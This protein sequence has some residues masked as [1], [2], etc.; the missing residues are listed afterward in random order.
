V[1]TMQVH[2]TLPRAKLICSSLPVLSQEQS[3]LTLQRI[4]APIVSY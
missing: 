1:S 2:S 3:I 4:S